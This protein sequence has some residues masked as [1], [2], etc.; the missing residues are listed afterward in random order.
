MRRTDP[1]GKE[2]FVGS[3][4]PDRRPGPWPHWR[5][6]PSPV[7][8]AVDTWSCNYTAATRRC[9]TGSARTRGTSLLATAAADPFP[10]TSRL[11]WRRPTGTN[12][13]EPDLPGHRVPL[14][15]GDPAGATATAPSTRPRA[16]VGVHGMLDPPTQPLTLLLADG[17]GGGSRHYDVDIDDQCYAAPRRLLRQGARRAS[18]PKRSS[19]STNVSAARATYVVVPMHMPSSIP[20][21][22]RLDPRARPAR[23]PRDQQAE[24]RESCGSGASA[25]TNAPNGTATPPGEGWDL[26]RQGLGCLAGRG[27]PAIRGS[28]GSRMSRPWGGRDWDRLRMSDVGCAIGTQLY[29]ALRPVATSFSEKNEGHR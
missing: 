2:L 28:T 5:A 18:R 19:C 17:A 25:L 12:R 21:R 22:C 16:E 4:R 7:F 23:G 11:V 1:A 14:R 15:H 27:F 24:H 3:C 29:P 20:P 26:A 6:A 9:R 13:T 10:S 8:V